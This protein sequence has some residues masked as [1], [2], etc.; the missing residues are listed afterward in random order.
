MSAYDEEELAFLAS[1]RKVGQ[2]LGMLERYFIEMVNSLQVEGKDQVFI[3]DV[4][5]AYERGIEEGTRMDPLAESNEEPTSG[6]E[7]N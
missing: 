1:V 5:L 2:K 3:D 7:N 4:S 6:E